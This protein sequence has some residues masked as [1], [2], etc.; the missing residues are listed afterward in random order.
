MKLENLNLI[1]MNTI[2]MI[3]T[4]GGNAFLNWCYSAYR[5]IKNWCKVL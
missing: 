5:T 1:E 4:N 2:E 3:E